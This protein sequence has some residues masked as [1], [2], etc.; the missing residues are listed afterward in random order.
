MSHLLNVRVAGFFEGS[1]VSLIVRRVVPPSTLSVWPTDQERREASGL[2][3]PVRTSPL[4]SW[5]RARRGH[6]GE[7]HTSG[8]VSFLSPEHHSVTAFG[9]WDVHR[10]WCHLL[11]NRKRGGPWPSGVWHGRCRLHGQLHQPVPTLRPQHPRKL[12]LRALPRREGAPIHALA[13]RR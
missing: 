8:R 10:S 4:R 12:S 7:R 6:Y 3:V 5:P 13:R 9:C 1:L 2:R 11:I